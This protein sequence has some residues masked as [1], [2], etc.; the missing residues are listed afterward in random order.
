MFTP[1]AGYLTSVGASVPLVLRRSGR[2]RTSEA[3]APTSAA[4]VG[5]LRHPCP[6]P[7]ERHS[8]ATTRGAGL[9]D[10]LRL[11]VSRPARQA[12]GWEPPAKGHAARNP[13]GHRPR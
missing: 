5:C 13:A 11:L 1:L 10:A 3:L 6:S 12:G 4:V 9:P 8:P 7:H 2:C